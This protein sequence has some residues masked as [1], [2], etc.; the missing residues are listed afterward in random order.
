MLKSLFSEGLRSTIFQYLSLV[1]NYL[2]YTLLVSAIGAE[3]YGYYAYALSMHHLL[4]LI[5]SMGLPI[6]ILRFQGED[7]Q[8]SNIASPFVSL[9]ALLIIVSTCGLSVSKIM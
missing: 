7:R 8:F 1:G 5:F 9:T 3:T 4:F 2:F 6:A